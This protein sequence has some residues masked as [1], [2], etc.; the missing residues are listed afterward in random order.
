MFETSSSMVRDAVRRYKEELVVVVNEQAKFVWEYTNLCGQKDPVGMV[1]RQQRMIRLQQLIG[2]AAQQQAILANY[3]KAG[4]ALIRWMDGKHI[5]LNLP[6]MN[7]SIQPTIEVILKGVGAGISA[8]TRDE[9]EYF[10]IMQ[11][12]SFFDTGEVLSI[13]LGFDELSLT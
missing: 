5:R 10:F 1:M 4:A 12:S 6:Q 8:L 9:S 13:H 2:E 3:I 11:W 7:L